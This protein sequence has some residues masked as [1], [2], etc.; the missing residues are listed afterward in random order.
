MYTRMSMCLNLC[1]HT[2]FPCLRRDRKMYYCDMEPPSHLMESF[3]P[4]RDNQIMGL[5]LLAISLGISNLAN[6]SSTV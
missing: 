2:R 1:V 3:R 6:V 5:E 4:R